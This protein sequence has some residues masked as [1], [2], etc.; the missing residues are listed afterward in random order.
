M[1]S[2]EERKKQ[3]AHW[4]IKQMRW[5]KVLQT[6]ESYLEFEVFWWERTCSEISDMLHG[7]GVNASGAAVE[8][9]AI[10]L[11]GYF[12][13]QQDNDLK[14]TVWQE[15]AVGWY[16]VYNE[17]AHTVIRFQL[18]WE[19]TDCQRSVRLTKMDSK[20]SLRYKIII[21]IIYWTKCFFLGLVQI[22]KCWFR[23]TWET[24]WPRTVY[25]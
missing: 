25:L 14:Q 5:D 24:I 8:G 4:D 6:D 3:R 7:A 18:L 21:S 13:L 11:A 2:W 10:D 22:H 20:Q 9:T 15:Q 12:P 23:V 17:S 19:Q 16:S 1:Q